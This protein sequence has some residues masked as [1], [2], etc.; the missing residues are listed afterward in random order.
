MQAFDDAD[1]PFE[2]NCDV[3][4]LPL[5]RDEEVDTKPSLPE[6]QAA[7]AEQHNTPIDFS[8]SIVEMEP[9]IDIVIKEESSDVS[10]HSEADNGEPS[11]NDAVQAWMDVDSEND[12]PAHSWIEAADKKFRSNVIKTKKKAKPDP[13]RAMCELCGIISN[14]VRQ[15]ERHYEAVHMDNTYDCDICGKRYHIISTFA[16][17]FTIIHSMELNVC[18]TLY[19]AGMYDH[20]RRVHI[21]REVIQYVNCDICDK[22]VSKWSLRDHILRHNKIITYP[23]QC[24]MCGKGFLRKE[25]LKV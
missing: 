6:L 13:T 19:K 15:H 21:K 2:S 22:R 16:I 18:R 23:F 14:N 7:I 24:F 10:A 8:R 12:F 3:N 20:M 17:S 11:L 1:E 5:A 9:I 4:E 25:K